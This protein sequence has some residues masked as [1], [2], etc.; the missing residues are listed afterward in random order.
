MCTT[1]GRSRRLTRTG[2]DGEEEVDDDNV[3]KAEALTSRATAHMFG[4]TQILQLDH[5]LYQRP[6]YPDGLDV[7]R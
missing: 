4:M 2:I 1:G 5:M 7:R 6:R 3:L